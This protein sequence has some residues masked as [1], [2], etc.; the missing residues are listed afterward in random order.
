MK[1]IN[2]HCLCFK[3]FDKML[4]ILHSSMVLQKAILSSTRYK[5]T[6]E[7]EHFT[8]VL[9]SLPYD[10][11]GASPFLGI[12]CFVLEDCF[13]GQSQWMWLVSCTRQGMLTQVPSPY[14]K[15][16]LNITF[17]TLPHPLH[18]FICAKDI[19]VTVL[20]LQVTGEGGGRGW[21]G[22]G[23]FIYVGVCVGGQGV[24]IIFF[25]FFVLFLCCC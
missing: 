8:K 14:P 22:W 12:F 18:C 20:L 19:M 24:G 23:R 25:L 3:L 21:E 2:C 17:L 7:V 5:Y 13:G 9:I 4:I 1:Y 10:L 15:C 6:P 16:E 11:L